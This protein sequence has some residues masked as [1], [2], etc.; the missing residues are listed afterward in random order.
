MYYEAIWLLHLICL[1]L[2]NVYIFNHFTQ[3]KAINR[4]KC[5]GITAGQ[6]IWKKEKKIWREDNKRTAFTKTKDNYLLQD[7]ADMIW[8]SY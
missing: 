4:L 2:S 1:N 5:K 7:I 3:D 8:I 6:R